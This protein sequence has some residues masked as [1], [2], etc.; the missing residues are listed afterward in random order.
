MFLTFFLKHQKKLGT[1]RVSCELSLRNGCLLQPTFT[2]SKVPSLTFSF[3][4]D[5]LVSE[6]IWVCCPCLRAVLFVIPNK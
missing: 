3:T 2:F 4:S 6:S 5:S 1:C